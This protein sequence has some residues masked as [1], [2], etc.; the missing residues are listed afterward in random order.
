VGNLIYNDLRSFCSAGL[1]LATQ[2]ATVLPYETQRNAGQ[3]NWFNFK[4]TSI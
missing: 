4:L 2:F 3:S 1:T